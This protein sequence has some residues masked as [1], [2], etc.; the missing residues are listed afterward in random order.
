MTNASAFIVPRPAWIALPAAALA[1]ACVGAAA[2][3]EETPVNA[4]PD[5]LTGSRRTRA[6]L[7]E[8]G[9]TP[10]AV[11]TTERLGNVA[12]GLQQRGWWNSLLD[13]G[14][15]LDTAKVGLWAGGSFLA[16]AHW[17]QNTRNDVMPASLTRATL[18]D[19]P[20]G[21]RIKIKGFSLPEGIR[22]RLLEMGLTE[23]I[24][25]RV[26]RFAPLGD[27]MEVQVRG[28]FLSLRTAEAK[29]VLVESLD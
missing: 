18:A 20:V 17:V 13:F 10:F 22:L 19:Q 2:L 24:E 5:T 11:W 1:V 14:V 15:E 26:V 3:A 12:G 16:Q 29:G 21:Q 7:E 9:V 27:P 4:P 28:Y 25:C 6:K 8:H 23:G